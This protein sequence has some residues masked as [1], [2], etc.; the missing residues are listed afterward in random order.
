LA[1]SG[2]PE[3]NREFFDL[4]RAVG[5]RDGEDA[6]FAQAFDQRAGRVDVRR[7]RQAAEVQDHRG[8]FEQLRR[9]LHAVAHFGGELRD[10]ERA[11]AQVGHADLADLEFACLFVID[12]RAHAQVPV[13]RC[14]AMAGASA[15][16]A[17]GCSSHG[18]FGKAS[19]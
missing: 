6:G 10:I 9:A 11:H 7:L 12:G 13:G 19:P 8:A 17:R 16:V 3:R 5:Q 4:A 1:S 15:R 14:A 18:A 2:R